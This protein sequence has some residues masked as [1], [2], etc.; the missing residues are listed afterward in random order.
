MAKG[1]KVVATVQ[2]GDKTEKVSV[3]ATANGDTVQVTRSARA[4]DIV[5]LNRNGNPVRVV[6]LKPEAVLVLS[7]EPVRIGAPK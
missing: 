4:V 2:V 7:E 3:E 1:D 6:T 5:Q